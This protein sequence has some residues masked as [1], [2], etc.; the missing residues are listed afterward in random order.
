[1]PMPAQPDNKPENFDPVKVTGVP[2]KYVAPKFFVGQNP[3]GEQLTLPV[4]VLRDWERRPG[5]F[6]VKMVEPEPT[7]EPESVDAT[8]EDPA[9]QGD[10]TEGAQAQAEV[11]SPLTALREEATELGIDWKP[12]WGL[13]RLTAA[14]AEAK[15]GGTEDEE[16][17]E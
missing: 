7:P 2:R 16:S 3:A 14:I 9:G 5:H 1:M 4:S 6:V 17:A 15:D 11:L 13:K 12:Q 8:P 10:L